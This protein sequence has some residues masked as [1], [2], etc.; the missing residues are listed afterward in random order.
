[1]KKTE[2]FELDWNKPLSPQLRSMPPTDDLK[3]SLTGWELNE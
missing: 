1:M 2:D 3:L